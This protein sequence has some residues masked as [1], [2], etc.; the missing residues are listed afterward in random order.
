[1]FNQI[2][3]Y[4]YIVNQ[5]Q[6]SLSL[7]LSLSPLSF[8]PIIHC[9]QQVFQTTSCVNTEL[10]Q[11]SSCVSAGTSEKRRPLENVTYVVIYWPLTEPSIKRCTCVNKQKNCGSR[12]MLDNDI[13]RCPDGSS[14]L[15]TRCRSENQLQ[16][17]GFGPSVTHGLATPSQDEKE[18]MLWSREEFGVNI[19][20]RP[21]L[22]S[23]LTYCKHHPFEKV[24]EIHIFIKKCIRSLLKSSLSVDYVPVYVCLCIRADVLWIYNNVFLLTSPA[25]SRMSCSSYLDGFRDEWQV[26][27]ELLFLGMLL[28][29]FVLNG[30]WPSWAFP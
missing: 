15:A 2:C 27:V 17:E 25:V 20:V 21:G 3:I 19:A 11:V 22:Y 4:I 23:F 29:G 24:W 30:S 28:P 1:M 18:V 10:F 7:S 8:F 9:Y 6:I 5:V 16:T 13:T 12:W 26:V 14:Q